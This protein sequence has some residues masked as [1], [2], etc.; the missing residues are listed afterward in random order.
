MQ[1]NVN[2]MGLQ[3]IDQDLSSLLPSL[4]CGWDCVYIERERLLPT[5]KSLLV[6][7]LLRQAKSMGT[8]ARFLK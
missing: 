1:K 7:F 5:M 6:P 4:G 8:Q 3:L 2:R